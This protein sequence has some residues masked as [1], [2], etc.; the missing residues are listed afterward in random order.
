MTYIDSKTNRKSSHWCK[1][2][3]TCKHDIVMC[4]R[5]VLWILKFINSSNLNFAWCDEL[6]FLHL[7]PVHTDFDFQILVLCCEF[8]WFASDLGPDLFLQE[9][10]LR[11]CCQNC[12][13]LKMYRKKLIPWL[14]DERSET[15]IKLKFVWFSL[16]FPV[17]TKTAKETLDNI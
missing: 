7:P 2:V 17:Q 9:I 6:I 15:T 10:I 12:C 13:P 4:R 8:C 1:K 11:N 5:C 3:W 16:V 14:S